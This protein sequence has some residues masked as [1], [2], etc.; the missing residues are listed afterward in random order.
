MALASPLTGAEVQTAQRR[1]FRTCGKE[2]P[3]SRLQEF[4]QPKIRL[5]LDSHS[6]VLQ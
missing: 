2:T 4:Q 3:P 6:S 5:E 1:C